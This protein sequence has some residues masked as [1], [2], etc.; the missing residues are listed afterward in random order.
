M[1]VASSDA[2]E[3]DN[4]GQD[5]QHSWRPVFEKI[6]F[7]FKSQYFVD[8]VMFHHFSLRDFRNHV[9]QL[10]GNFPSALFVFAPH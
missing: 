6:E 3:D 7:S 9:S 4:L 10:T 1:Q 2:E 8:L 5:R